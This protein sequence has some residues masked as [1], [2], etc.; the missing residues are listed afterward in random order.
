MFYIFFFSVGNTEVK[1][2]KCLSTLFYTNN[3]LFK[4]ANKHQYPTFAK[5]HSVFI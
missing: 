3:I 5:F 1:I 4:L 2:N